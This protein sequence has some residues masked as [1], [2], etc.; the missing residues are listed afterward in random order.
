MKTS[1]LRADFERCQK[2]LSESDAYIEDAQAVLDA[3]DTVE[4]DLEDLVEYLD[5]AEWQA[6]MALKALKQMGKALRRERE[7]HGNG[8][9][10]T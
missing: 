1:L 10:E 7:E 8:Y 5:R 4:H 9:K 3:P 2:F 6:L